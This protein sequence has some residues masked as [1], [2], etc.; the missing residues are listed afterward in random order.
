MDEV[1]GDDAAGLGGQELLPG[2]AG[3]GRG[4]DTGVMHDL[5]DRGGRDEVA[6]PDGFAMHPRCPTSDYRS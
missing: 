3:G 6:E 4:A 1:G 2:R 5:P